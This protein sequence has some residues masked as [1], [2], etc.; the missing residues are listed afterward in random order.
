MRSRPAEDPFPPATILVVESN[1]AAAEML[2][3]VLATAGYQTVSTAS[4]ER[5]LSTQA[6]LKP[7]LIVVGPSRTDMYPAAL[8]GALRA[9]TG[10]PILV[11]SS[12]IDTGTVEQVLAAGAWECLLVPIPARD[13][14]T[15]ITALLHSSRGRKSIAIA[16]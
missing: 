12:D 16:V 5:A 9:R 8:C 14:Q 4:G 11:L 13:L 15:H 6:K 10:A 1:P 7:D 2:V 3:M